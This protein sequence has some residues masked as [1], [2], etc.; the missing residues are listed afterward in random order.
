[1]VS[2]S[3]LQTPTSK[4]KTVTNEEFPWQVTTFFFLLDTFTL[5]DYYSAV[6]LFLLF[7]STFMLYPP[8]Y[9]PSPGRCRPQGQKTI[10][11]NNSCDYWSMAR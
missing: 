2:T 9:T 4:K 5:R 3:T 11:C 8:V 10:I 6:T 7:S 1:M